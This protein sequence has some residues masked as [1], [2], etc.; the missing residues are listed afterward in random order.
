M[1]VVVVA[2]VAVRVRMALACIAGGVKWRLIVT[3]MPHYFVW[4]IIIIDPRTAIANSHETRRSSLATVQVAT[5][6]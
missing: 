4:C 6:A 1:R 5:A 3:S 2:Y